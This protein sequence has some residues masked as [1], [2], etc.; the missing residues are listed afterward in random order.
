MWHAPFRE[1]VKAERPAFAQLNIFNQQ[2][3]L[4]FWHLLPA[5][6]IGGQQYRVPPH[7][8]ANWLGKRIFLDTNGDGTASRS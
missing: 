3:K 5:L 1:R 6:V 4:L 8:A 7:S 2:F